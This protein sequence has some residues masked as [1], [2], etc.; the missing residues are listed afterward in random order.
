M[1][2]EDQ[3]ARQFIKLARGF[4]RCDWCKRDKP[5]NGRGLCRHCNDV[6]LNLEKTQ[7]R[8]PH[9]RVFTG[10]WFLRLAREKKNS[11]IGWGKMLRNILDGDVSPLQLEHWLWL[12]AKRVGSGEKQV[13]G[14]ATPLGRM[15]TPAQRQV[16][17][18][19]FWEI[20]SEHASRHRQ[21]YAL[22]SSHKWN[23]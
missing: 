18:Y 17:A 15:F 19:L 9:P 10:K 16:L 14:L 2:Y 21:S 8:D 7:K 3:E 5:R 4:S 22:Q 1:P 20:L 6:R 12:I 23:L 11:C 13:Y